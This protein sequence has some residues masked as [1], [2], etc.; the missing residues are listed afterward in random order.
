M[1]HPLLVTLLANAPLTPDRVADFESFWYYTILGVGMSTLVVL[2]AVLVFR[3]VR[4]MWRDGNHLA[5]V[6][7]AGS[8][9]FFCVLFL[10]MALTALIGVTHNAET[11]PPFQL[12]PS[13]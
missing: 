5:A 13:G 9:G 7:V 2:A 10:A 6:V 1:T 8:A 11:P 3:G 4:P 12:G